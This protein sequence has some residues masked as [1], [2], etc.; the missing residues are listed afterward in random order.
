MAF[1]VAFTL[2]SGQSYY[3]ILGP[4]LYSSSIYLN[5]LNLTIGLVT[6]N[7][8]WK[9]YVYV[10]SIVQFLNANFNNGNIEIFLCACIYVT[11]ET[12]HNFLFGKSHNKIC[13]IILLNL[14]ITLVILKVL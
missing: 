2:I 14:A 13:F 10:L 8:K 7:E 3:Y 1:C 9:L 6:A 12:Y 5:V 4:I 11:W